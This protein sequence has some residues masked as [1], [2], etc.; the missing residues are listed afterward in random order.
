MAL[1]E[2]S[3]RI[4]TGNFDTSVDPGKITPCVLVLILKWLC[5]FVISSLIINGFS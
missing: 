3:C 4:S 1:Q 2:E 5:N